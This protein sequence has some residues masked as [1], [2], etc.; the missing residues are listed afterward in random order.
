[1]DA[2]PSD[3]PDLLSPNV[4]SRP[5]SNFVRCF[6]PYNRGISGFSLDIFL[7]GSFTCSETLIP[8][9][10]MQNAAQNE[11]NLPSEQTPILVESK[12]RLLNSNTDIRL[13]LC[14]KTD[15]LLLLVQMQTLEAHTDHLQFAPANA[16]HVL[17]LQVRFLSSSL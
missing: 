6:P 8:F 15:F 16:T 1:M 12:V 9:W 4:C 11:Q 14:M 7:P 2:P 10:L 5:R 3:V 13:Y 17:D